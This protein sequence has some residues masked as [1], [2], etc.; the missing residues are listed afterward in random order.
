MA[1]MA[2]PA[3]AQGDIAG[4][5]L[6]FGMATFM[7]LVIVLIRRKR[8]VNMVPAVCASAFLCALI[9]WPFASPL[10][11]DAASFSLLALFGTSQFGMG[12]L[13]LALGTPLVS[14][15]RG[16][17]IG[18]L[19]APL[20]TLWVWLAFAERPATLTLIGGAIVL[21]AVVADLLAPHPTSTTCRPERSEGP[22]GASD[23]TPLAIGD[24]VL[25]CAQDDRESATGVARS[26][27]TA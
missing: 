11:V 1:I 4:D 23:G 12:L 9:V 8:G 25:R 2:A 26:R 15:T 24:G 18:V 19:Q 14:A 7:S 27:Q 20:A 10:Q 6:A 3:V 17:L 21:A 13:L 16:A 5:V 22:D